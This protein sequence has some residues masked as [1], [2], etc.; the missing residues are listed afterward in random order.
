MQITLIEPAQRFYTCPFSNLYLAGL[1]EW[2]SLG[3]GFDGLRKQGIEVVHASAEQLDARG[4]TV[5]LSNGSTLRWD[6]LVLSPGVDMQWN[7]L[8]GYDQ[9]AA[10]HAPHAW[11]AGAQTQL[12]KRQLQAMKD[13][14]T[15]IMTIPE[16]PFR[17][18]P[19][20]YERAAMVA[21]YFRQHKPKSKILLLDAKTAFSKQALFMQGWKALY[22]NMIEWVGQVDDGEVVRVDARR[23]EV[24]TAFGQR[25]RADVLNVIPPQK[26]GLIAERAGVTNASGW[27]PVHGGT[28]ESSQVQDVFV[29]G[30]ASIAA[31]MPKSAFAA[32]TQGKL[33]AAVIAAQ[34]RG[35]ALP[36]ASFSNT[37]YSLIGPDY[38]I[39]V[40]GVYKAE[41]GR[42]VE[43]PDSGGVSPLDADARFRR[44]EA[45]YGQGWYS[46]ITA[47]IW[48]G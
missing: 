11:K 38:G 29:V 37:C 43:M 32:N 10:E 48:G 42:V 30:D 6:K 35:Q 17:C 4:R 8:Q 1:R 36:Q 40:A 34:L 2:D 16:N 31:P 12:L 27:V 3:H 41:G 21:H 20:P 19:G 33:V 7:K 23:R 44:M 13:G 25:H 28:F 45:L 15:F 26:A 14:G 39:S 5:K 18:P 22:G 24:E 47:D 9:A 46:A